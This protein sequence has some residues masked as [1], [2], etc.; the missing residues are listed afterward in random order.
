MTQKTALIIGASRGLGAALA[1]A[2]CDTHHIIA[3]AKTTGAL[4]E[5]DD[6]IQARGG[7]ATLAPMD[8]TN[9]DAM[10]TLCRGIYD[11]WGS[12]DLWL[13]TAIHAAP[14]APTNHVDTK[15]MA[16]SVACNITATS[17]LITYVSP[18]LGHAGQAVFFDDP[19]VGSKF[20]GAYGAT[21]AAQ[22]ALAKS[23]QAE[24]A[25]IGALRSVPQC[26]GEETGRGAE[27]GVGAGFWVDE[28]SIP[29]GV[30]EQSAS[31]DHAGAKGA[32]HPSWSAS[33][34][35][36]VVGYGEVYGCDD[37]ESHCLSWF[38]SR[39]C[40]RWSFRDDIKL[41]LC[42]DDAFVVRD[43]VEAAAG[44]G[45]PS[46]FSFVVPPYQGGPSNSLESGE[47]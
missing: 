20:Y 25:K 27:E 9:A 40:D 15:D 10:A 4:E 36:D 16:K 34:D 6:R 46:N 29:R 23:W 13:H 41:F 11:R 7:S 14:L 33:N 38:L 3:V 44:H 12:L 24:A 18:L 5:L 8:V 39:H 42:S 19:V 26:F 21:K 17:T 37:A 1:E 43:R 32:C 2:L 22:I 45:W 47:K 28:G 30:D 31:T 35:H